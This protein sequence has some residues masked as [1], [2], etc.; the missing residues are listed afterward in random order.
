MTALFRASLLASVP[1]L[2]TRA[3]ISQIQPVTESGRA[4]HA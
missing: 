4:E 2:T 3:E 1:P